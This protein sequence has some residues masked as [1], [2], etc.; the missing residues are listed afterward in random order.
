MLD[1]GVLEISRSDPI[2]RECDQSG[3]DLCEKVKLKLHSEGQ[4]TI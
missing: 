4:D 2:E 1:S 3:E